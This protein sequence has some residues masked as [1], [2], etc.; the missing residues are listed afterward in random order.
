MARIPRAHRTTD[1]NL[2]YD[3]ARCQILIAWSGDLFVAACASSPSA[4]KCCLA[5]TAAQHERRAFSDH[6]PCDARQVRAAILHMPRL[7][8]RYG[9]ASAAKEPKAD[10]M[11]EVVPKTDSTKLYAT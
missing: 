11:G 7:P 2:L 6:R 4:V 3:D 1:S 5:M 8:K 9:W 10:S